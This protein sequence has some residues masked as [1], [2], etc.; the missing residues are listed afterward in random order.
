MGPGFGGITRE[1]IASIARPRY[2]AH[3]KFYPL[4]PSA[5]VLAGEHRSKFPHKASW[6]FTSMMTLMA[7][8]TDVCARFEA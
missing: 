7:V 6:L 2:W 5:H 8:V 1:L 3:A 4:G